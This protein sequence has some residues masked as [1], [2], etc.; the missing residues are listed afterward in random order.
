MEFNFAL[1]FGIFIAIDI[2]IA[3]LVFYFYGKKGFS[4]KDK[5][6][7]RKKWQEAASLPDQ[8]LTVLEADKLLDKLLHKKGYAGSLGEKL[9][10]AGTLFSDINAVWSAHKLRN[11]FA[12]ELDF[13][14]SPQEMGSAIRS[15][16]KAFRDLQ[17]L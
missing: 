8:R 2:V 6:F 9:K 17:I 13:K 12:H 11:R 1:I 15:F 14:P 7:F 3:V 4:E 16:E 10:K 5:E